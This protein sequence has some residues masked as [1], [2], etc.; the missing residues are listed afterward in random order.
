MIDDKELLAI[1]NDPASKD[2]GFKI[3]LS[4]Y[5]ERLYW[6]IRR[7]VEIH[8]DADDVMQNT[9]IKIYKS[10]HKFN[11]DSTLYTWI[12]RIAT[13]ESITFINKRKKNKS[14]SIAGDNKFLLDSLKSDSY[15]DE[16]EANLK[17]TMAIASLPDRQKAVFNMRYYD[18]LKY[19]QIAEI[20]NLSVGGLKASYHHAVKKIEEFIKS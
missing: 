16:T 10:I 13:N 17:L 2:R 11:G 5:Q 7:M 14:E 8:E 9:F 19:D 6:H 1:I 18:E 20:L 3:L 12:N 15:F 4:V